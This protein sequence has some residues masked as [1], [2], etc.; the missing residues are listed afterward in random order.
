MVDVESKGERAFPDRFQDGTFTAWLPDGSGIAVVGRRPGVHS[1]GNG[2]QIFLQPYPSGPLRRV[3]N[4]MIEYRNISFSS[5]GQQMVSIGFD[6]AI[7]MS[8]VPFESGEPRLLPSDRLDGARGLTW[9]PDGS[10]L[11]FSRVI[12]GRPSIASMRT[13]GS[14]LREIVNDEASA[15]PAVSPDG[16]TLV[17][18]AMRGAQTGVW[19]SD[20]GGGSVTLLA[21]VPDANGIV[22]SPDGESVV[23]SSTMLGPPAALRVPIAGGEPRP[24]AIRF[25]RPAISP[26][27]TLIAGAHREQ[28]DGPVTLT[29]VTSDTGTVVRSFPLETTTLGGSTGWTS[30]GSSVLFTTV[31]RYNVW[32]RKLPN[33]E[34]EKITRFSDL[35]II[36]FA[37]S[38]DGHTLAVCRGVQNRDAFLFTGF[39]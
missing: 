36:R 30:D 2:G 27:G 39:Q 7:R 9:M 20:I 15:W 33:G 24:I 13:D 6:I 14:D 18:F 11:V 1:T 37:V 4:D 3:T 34:P 21:Q 23:V 32:K 12:A 16:K 25:D 10:R 8:L 26:D 17:Y 38:P 35:A 28:P 19:R 5:D 22:F 29:V 31:E